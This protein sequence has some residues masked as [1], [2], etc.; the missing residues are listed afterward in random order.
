MRKLF[1]CLAVCVILIGTLAPISFSSKPHIN[2]A[3]AGAIDTVFGS[4]ISIEGSGGSFNLT[5]SVKYS[6]YWTRAQ[7]TLSDS[8]IDL[9][10]RVE[11]KQANNT[12][13]ELLNKEID[14]PNPFFQ[15]DIAKSV[16]Q[17][18][19]L[20]DGTYQA[21]FYEKYGTVP[22]YNPT[23]GKIRFT[24]VGGAISGLTKYEQAVAGETAIKVVYTPAEQPLTITETTQGDPTKITLAF[25][26]E[27]Q[28]PALPDYKEDISEADLRVLLTEIG[29]DGRRTETNIAVSIAGTL[30]FNTVYRT[31]QNIN[32]ALT[33][34]LKYELYVYDS[35]MQDS[36]NA[37]NRSKSFTAKFTAGNLTNVQQ[38]DE[39]IGTEVTEE[40]QEGIIVVNC[41]WDDFGCAMT[42]LLVDLLTAVPNFVA[43]FVGA[44]SDIFLSIAIQPGTYGANTD[45]AIYTGIS[46]VWKIIR[47]VANIGFIFALFVAA[48]SLI[49]NQNFMGFNPGKTVFRVIIM[50]LLVN[51]SLLFCRLIIQT[52]DVFS[53]VLYN[54]I[55]STVVG[56]GGA[57]TGAIARAYKAAT[58]PITSVSLP[59]IALANPQRLFTEAKINPA[60]SGRNAAYLVVGFI[61]F[62]VLLIMIWVFGSMLLIFV[63]RIFG[64]WI[65][66]ILSPLAFVSH[67]IPFMENNK[68]FGFIPWLKNFVQ[69][70]FLIPIYLFFVYMTAK[71]MNIGGLGQTVSLSGRN[72][73]INVLG[74][75]IQVAIPLIMASF[76]LIKGKKVAYDM[77]GEVGEIAASWTNKITGAALGVATGGTA[78][79]GRQTLGAAGTAV[80]RSGIVKAGLQRGGISATMAKKVQNM[81]NAVG[82]STFDVRNSPRIMK[83][84]NKFTQAATGTTDKKTGQFIPGEGIDLGKNNLNKIGEGYSTVGGFGAAKDRFVAG[85]EEKRKADALDTAERL[86]K[87]EEDKAKPVIDNLTKEKDIKQEAFEAVHGQALADKKADLDKKKEEY[88]EEKKGFDNKAADKIIGDYKEKEENIAK[89]LE[90]T[91]DLTAELVRLESETA[92]ASDPE[93]WAQ[94]SYDE[95]PFSKA[96]ANGVIATS[97]DEFKTAYGAETEAKRTT[98]LAELQSEKAALTTKKTQKETEQRTEEASR[99]AIKPRATFTM[100]KKQAIDDKKKEMDDKERIYKDFK[101]DKEENSPEGQ[102]LTIAKDNLKKANKDLE[103]NIKI[104]VN[105]LAQNQT[106]T[107]IFNANVIDAVVTNTLDKTMSGVLNTITLGRAGNTSTYDAN[108]TKQR[109]SNAIYQKFGRPASGPTP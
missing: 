61:D 81:G 33:P 90:E 22:L 91:R 42:K 79:I 44:M 4:D 35:N 38:V 24:V 31:T 75:V 74:I 8:E 66:M 56:N 89:I 80:S 49:L 37:Y 101:K 6:S 85:R 106:K 88:E 16:S 92:V 10:Y 63:G 48:F 94:K 53:N 108:R 50:A 28:F 7:H 104:A 58:P 17:P 19:S 62:F 21:W 39:N 73:L 41:S 2:I 1:A 13:T 77:S 23:S 27:Y 65:G 67:A 64:L 100:N 30:K 46:D 26:V 93:A 9:Y 82:N 96:D 97:F 57:T 60:Q 107:G 99:D 11:K 15:E 29:T 18:V 55:G 12:Y 40:A 95:S 54:T 102:A 3:S 43:I 5:T 20:P 71:L 86:K 25:N 52:A 47:D 45:S 98:K 34:G 72:W 36:N 109:T 76:M 69:L 105:K 68:Y 70:A 51:F 103:E 84:F 87:M 78:M 32:H 83:P 14:P 59:I